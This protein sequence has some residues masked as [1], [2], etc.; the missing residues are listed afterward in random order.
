MVRVKED[1]PAWVAVR[2]ASA[3]PS[4]GLVRGMLH[5]GGFLAWM[6][7]DPTGVI[8]SVRVAAGERL[9]L[10]LV[11]ERFFDK[12]EGPSRALLERYVARAATGVAFTARVV[13]EGLGETRRYEA[14]YVPHERDGEVDEIAIM[15][16]ETTAQHA[17]DAERQ[18]VRDALDAT[19]DGVVI[20]TA[21]PEP[22]VVFANVAYLTW[23]GAN[24]S[25]V[26]GK[27]A[28]L[29]GRWETV[30]GLAPEEPFRQALATD[31]GRTVSLVSQ[32]PTQRNERELRTSPVRGESAR[33]VVGI[34]RDVTVQRDLE[35]QVRRATALEALGQLAGSAAHDFNNLLASMWVE[36]AQL[37]RDA[38]GAHESIIA[39]ESCVQQS[40][41][42]LSRLLTMTRPV[43]PAP[44]RVDLRE[45]L[46]RQERMLA[47]IGAGRVTLRVSV[48]E[49][50]V[51]LFADEAQL[52]QVWLNLVANACDAMPNGGTVEIRVRLESGLARIDVIDE[53]LGMSA[54]TLAKAFTPFF[55]TK[56]T[57]G[58]GL[59]LTTVRR[60]VEEHGGVV[61]LEASPSR[62][63]RVSVV[64]PLLEGFSAPPP[65]PDWRTSSEFDA[66]SPAHVLI[67]EDQEVLRRG[68][69][70]GL[71]RA[72]YRVSEACDGVDA[73][74]VLEREQDVD[75]VLSDVVMP[76][77]DGVALV[78]RLAREWPNV[79]VLMMSGY[80]DP[81]LG[82][83]P[84]DVR[85][86]AKPFRTRE[87]L[88][89]LS[90]LLNRP[91]P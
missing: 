78:A 60:I 25:D 14:H 2:S 34:V 21:D 45:A 47:R 89:Q 62:G 48:G 85:L 86:L 61:N 23:L 69:A 5:P 72:G 77:M 80:S 19:E 74:A 59:G 18:L 24:E 30:E 79:R 44:S 37:R 12:L 17:R 53:G 49:E 81:A 83:L 65:E 27:P 4:A 15:V 36:L 22:R 42:L 13:V 38:P 31:V 50:P 40:R 63:C 67:V 32:D 3:T 11:G 66:I 43:P 91:T 56:G 58:T 64:L 16:R 51:W 88:A 55:S 28:R 41:T 87:L 84:S 35:E 20:C 68:V 54:S 82:A 26:I 90:A 6:V 9:D 76:R 33:H 7:V 46:L 73:L 39:L 29:A 10:P 8:R 57:H 75:L 52:E 1:R 71:Q 70:R